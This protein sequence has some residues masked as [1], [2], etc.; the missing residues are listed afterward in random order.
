MAGRPAARERQERLA[1]L[2]GA[3]EVLRDICDSIVSGGTLPEWCTAH[4]V[5]YQPV[6][7][8][9]NA[10][11]HRRER[12]KMAQDLRGEFLSELV[13]RN[14]RE[15]VEVDLARA[16]GADGALLPM[17]QIPPDIRRAL[18]GVEV[19]ELF[20]GKGDKREHVG[21]VRKIKRV[22]PARALELLGKYRRMFV[23]KVEHDIGPTLEKLLSASRRPPA[24]QDVELPAPGTGTGA[25]P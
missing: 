20:A 5:A 22:D 8:W 24:R 23:D 17:D 18:A 10:E 13:V 9:I 3:P 7:A 12:F 25:P 14:L 11:D 19:E 4:G 21:T 15:F 6:A 2:L 16:F 1:E